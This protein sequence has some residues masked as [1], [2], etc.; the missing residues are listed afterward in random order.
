MIAR[1]V[2]LLKKSTTTPRMEVFQKAEGEK[3]VK[4]EY[5]FF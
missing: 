5:V 1:Q 3:M 2:G 4:I